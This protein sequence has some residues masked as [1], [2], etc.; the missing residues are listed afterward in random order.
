MPCYAQG[1]VKGITRTNR[2]I[3]KYLVTGG[4]GFIGS[5]LTDSLIQRGDSVIVLDDLSTGR[6][7][8]V[9]HLSLNP[10]FEFVQGSILNVDLVDD[11]VGRV[12]E[13]FHLAAAV[14]VNLIVEKPLESLS[15]NI[16]GSEVVLEKA[17]K[18][19]KPILVTSTSEI[20]GKNTSDSLREDDDRILGSPLKTR[21]S[22]SEAKA[23]EEVLAFTYWK[24]KGL[25]TRIVRLF[26]T[27]GPRQVGHYGMVVPRF[28]EAAMSGKD[29]TIYG[30]GKQTR[31]FGHIADIVSGI[32]LVADTPNTIGKA[33]NLGNTSEI[34][35][36]DLAELIVSKLNSKSRIIFVPY[37]QAYEEGFEDMHRRVP[38]I[39]AIS[40]LTGWV[41]QIEIDQI[42]DDVAQS[43][44]K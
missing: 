43:L 9:S 26:N 37:D 16:R 28:I 18:Y 15:T 20:Y 3:L 29:I 19:G 22:Y 33:L 1:K 41:P 17:N 39:Q 40:E 13:I 36:I 12:D 6:H 42:I 38:N 2:T 14:G 35:I 27:V 34:S 30:D 23:I 10:N 32:L 4:A 8:N 7:K 25:P 24:T 21:W 31:C 11:V 5:H 44:R